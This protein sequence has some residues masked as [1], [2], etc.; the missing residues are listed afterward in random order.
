MNSSVKKKK[1]KKFLVVDIK[2]HFSCS[3]TVLG[4][5]LG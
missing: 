2:Y 3:T 4:S 5:F 1:K